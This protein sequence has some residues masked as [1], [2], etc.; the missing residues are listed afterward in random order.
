MTLIEPSPYDD[1]TRA[2]NFE[3][4]YNAVLL[5]FAEFVKGL[6]AKDQLTATDFNAPVVAMLE[7]AKGEDP[8]LAQKII[9]DRVHPGPGAHLLM[10]EAL[11]KSWNAPSVVTDVEIDAA[12]GTAEAAGAI[13][14][15]LKPESVDEAAFK[16]LA[17]T[18]VP[19]IGPGRWDFSW[20]QAD[21]ALP[22][23]VD[24]TDPATALA[25]RD[26]D[27]EDALNREVLRV[28]G[29]KAEQY[30][31]S[32]DGEGIGLFSQA[33][34]ERG[35]NLAELPTPMARQAA[36]VHKLTERRN[37][38]H[39][40]RWHWIEVSLPQDGTTDAINAS[41]PPLLN[42]LDQEEAAVTAEQRA[43]AQPVSHYYQ[44][45]AQSIGTK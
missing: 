31:L 18:Q 10:A 30:L 36:K 8:A 23:P 14:S 16:V 35:I 27:F 12:A 25:L 37:H 15:G 2:P 43:A 4:G 19:Q 20:T 11:L 28:T 3:G 34:L 44:L 9:N 32:I 38:I 1:F 5:R 17:A 24:L 39:F 42:A 45:E 33:Q 40:V 26:S 22:M 29:L 7:R 21:D 41:V 13:V 6:A